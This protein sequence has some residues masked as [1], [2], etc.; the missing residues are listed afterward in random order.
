MGT[1]TNSE[2][3]N[4]MRH[5]AAFHQSTLFVKVKKDLQTK[6]CNIF[7]LNIFY[8]NFNLVR[9]TYKYIQVTAIFFNIIPDTPR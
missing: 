6:E 9:Y 3:L 4:E 7:S 1:F 2:D 5:D 8:K